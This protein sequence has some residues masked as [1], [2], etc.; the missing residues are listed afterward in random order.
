MEPELSDGSSGPGQNAHRLDPLIAEH[1]VVLRRVATAITGDPARAAAAVAAT[2]STARRRLRS[3]GGHHARDW[4]LVRVAREANRRLRPGWLDQVV[5]AVPFRRRR[6][7]RA[8]PVADGALAEI[9]DHLTPEDRRMLALRHAAGLTS[10]EIAGQLELTGAGVRAHL[11]DLHGQLRAALAIGPEAED[12]EPLSERQLEAR[13]A[14]RL[15]AH[16][17]RAVAASAAGLRHPIDAP[18]SVKRPPPPRRTPTRTPVPT[19]RRA[20]TVAVALVLVAAIA[21]PVSLRLASGGGPAATPTPIPG[22]LVPVAGWT[23]RTADLGTPGSVLSWAPDDRHLAVRT[24]DGEIRVYD[25]AGT[26]LRTFSGV[27]VAWID[28]ERLAVLQP[29]VGPAAD[30]GSVT[31]RALDG[32]D[33]LL[34]ST[35][36]PVSRLLGGAG[37]AVELSEAFVPAAVVP[38]RRAFVILRSDGLSKPIS[39]TPVAW[40]PDGARLAYIREPVSIGDGMFEGPLHVLDAATGADLAVDPSIQQIAGAAFDPTGRWI[41]VGEPSGTTVTGTELALLDTVNGTLERSSIPAAGAA[42]AWSADG[43]LVV[44][45]GRTLLRWRPGDSPVALRWEPPA[46]NAVASLTA[47]GGQVAMGLTDGPGVASTVAGVEPALLALPG[48]AMGSA[49][50]S[51]DGTRLAYTRTRSS[52]LVLATVPRVAAPGSAAAFPSSGATGSIPGSSPSTP[53]APSL[54]GIPILSLPHLRTAALG[55]DAEQHPVAIWGPHVY[56]ISGFDPQGLEL[57]VVDV[58]RNSTFLTDIITAAMLPGEQVAGMWTDGVHLVIEMF[59]RLGPQS[60]QVVPCPSDMHQPAAWRLLAAPLG[61]D[62]VPTDGLSVLASGTASRAVTA[63]GGMGPQ[64]ALTSPPPV[65]VKDGRVAYAVEAPTGA[66]PWASRIIVRQL[67]GG[68]VVETQAAGDPVPW[69]GLGDDLLAWTEQA[70][71]SVSEAGSGGL[72]VQLPFGTAARPV[73]LPS[74]PGAVPSTTFLVAGRQLVYGTYDQ[75]GL[76]P[77]SA[78]RLDPSTGASQRLPAASPNQSCMPVSA[79]A[80]LVFLQCWTDM[81]M[82]LVWREGSGVALV[83]PGAAGEA[84]VLVGGG[85][86]LLENFDSDGVTLQAF[87][88]S[89]IT[90]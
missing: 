46:P 69:I 18:P 70:D 3:L 31:V 86:A 27:D 24:D 42:T 43:S 37:L 48:H 74:G 22:T 51:P 80:G 57:S 17:D 41:V 90:P 38:T 26:L 64:C 15:I 77:A 67:S 16:L 79:T 19:G 89:D 55:L 32:G 88:L 39:G 2:W 1:D 45:Q 56:A 49:A 13:I 66:H 63:P 52:E 8:A 20:L 82:N 4:L 85:W 14:G 11:A 12:A 23:E 21:V 84:G 87:P 50:A 28:S 65:D 40:T 9:L 78:W 62:G 53:A 61:E 6:S 33:D 54:P 83:T 81:S 68:A 10:E 34:L 72:Q 75:S 47:V 76:Q 71:A 29:Q 36:A 25:P 5:R 59:R 73:S 35:A 60:D 7:P 30:A 44:G 58:Q